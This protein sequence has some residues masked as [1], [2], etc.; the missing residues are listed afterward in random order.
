MARSIT[1]LMA[2]AAATALSAFAWAQPAGAPPSVAPSS[3][4]RTDP[5]TANLARQ[6][7]APVPVLETTTATAVL[8]A[9]TTKTAEL[10]QL[11]V[12]SAA[13]LIKKLGVVKPKVE[14]SPV[15]GSEKDE[16]RT[17]KSFNEAD[18]RKLLA[19]NPEVIYR[20]VYR[21]TPLP[22]PMIIPWIRNLVVLEERFAEAVDLL[23]QGKVSAGREALRG[24]INDFPETDIA[25]Q[26]QEMLTKID[27]MKRAPG[28]KV[29]GL[30]PTKTPAPIEIQLDP[31]VVVRV[32]L[33]N[34]KNPAES[35]ALITGRLYRVGDILRGLPTHK[36]IA[37]GTTS[38]TIEVSVRDSKK[39][40]VVPVKQPS[41]SVKE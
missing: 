34:P 40:F 31:G 38:V 11:A 32:V 5:A 24:I 21:G 23:G 1:T 16:A 27:G 2:A 10:D 28:D 14:M 8:E 18:I 37:I 4:I 26:A 36:V 9:I 41:Q 6:M 19:E 3:Q 35:S 33:E 12:D 13:E 7:V 25:R 30:V 20:T 15:F 29:G 22:D 17:G 39:Q